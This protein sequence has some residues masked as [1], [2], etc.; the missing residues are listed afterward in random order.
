MWLLFFL[1]MPAASVVGRVFPNF[2]WCLETILYMHM[3][4]YKCC[5]WISVADV[6]EEMLHD[7][8]CSHGLRELP[9]TFLL[10][11]QQKW[12]H[13]NSRSKQDYKFTICKEFPVTVGVTILLTQSTRKIKMLSSLNHNLETWI[14]SLLNQ[15]FALMSKPSIA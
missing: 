15:S 14:A 3:I 11:Y 13:V 8:L 5:K 9:C 1:H 4:Q 6:I 2:L 12:G 7:H 10:N